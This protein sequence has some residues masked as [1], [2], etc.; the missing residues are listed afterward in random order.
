MRIMFLVAACA[1]ALLAAPLGSLAQTHDAHPPAGAPAPSHD[2]SGASGSG[3]DATSQEGMQHGGESNA[4]MMWSM[5][6]DL[7]NIAY[8][9]GLYGE[10]EKTYKSALKEARAFPPADR[11]LGISLN[12]LAGVY[13]MEGRFSDSEQVAR[14]GLAMRE[15]AFGPSDASVADSLN[16]L[17]LVRH[18]QGRPDEAEALYRRALAIG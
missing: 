4:E 5:Y 7:G 15:A 1:L 3:G 18:A 8:Q 16:T 10:A 17:A 2:H 9:N 6:T 11:R 14:E 12:N 13:R